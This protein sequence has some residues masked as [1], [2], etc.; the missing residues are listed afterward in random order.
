M[1]LYNSEKPSDIKVKLFGT[2]KHKDLINSVVILYG[3]HQVEWWN[4]EKFVDYCEFSCYGLQRS[5]LP[6]VLL[7]KISNE[8]KEVIEV[9]KKWSPEI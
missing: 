2:T 8:Y 6:I 9:N 5:E 7:C 4:T 1:F 3:D